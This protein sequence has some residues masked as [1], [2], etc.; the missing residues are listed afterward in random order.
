MSEK[1]KVK[2]AKYA[3]KIVVSGKTY[4]IRDLLKQMGFWYIHA[5][6]CWELPLKDTE[7]DYYDVVEMLSE[8]AEVEKGKTIYRVFCP[9][10]RRF[11]DS[12][13]LER[14]RKNFLIHLVEGHGLSEEEAEEKVKQAFEE[15]T[16]WI[17]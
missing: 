6:R 10:C 9:Y 14:L 8:V 3:G 1:P 2:V 4:P 7:L 13:S 5:Q 16:E 11:G 12:E 15:L 17:V